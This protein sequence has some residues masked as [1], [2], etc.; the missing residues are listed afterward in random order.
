[1]GENILEIR[2]LDKFFG[3]T[4]A[5]RGIDLTVKRGEIHGLIGENG[6]GKS[7]LLSQIAGMYPSDSG[8]MTVDGKPY[9][10][11][12]PMDANDFRISMVMQELGVVGNLPAGVNVF[13][14]RTGQFARGGIVNL[15]A[16]NKAAAEQFRKWELPM[17]ALNKLTDGMMIEERKMLAIWIT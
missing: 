11:H 7:T 5:N 3:P 15:R 4:H 1:M 10:P 12:S 2:G 9:K 16:L 8:E 6:S 17:P 14:G 13:R